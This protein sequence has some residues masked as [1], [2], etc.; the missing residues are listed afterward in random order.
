FKGIRAGV[1]VLI[2]S[3]CFKLFKKMDKRLVNYLIL[4]S[5]VALSLILSIST[6][7]IIIF[8]AVVGIIYGVFARKVGKTE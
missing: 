6:V 8:G 1:V 5:S 2:F 4:V 7:G 3:A